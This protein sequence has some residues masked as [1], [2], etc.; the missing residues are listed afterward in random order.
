MVKFAGRCRRACRRNA[1][2]APACAAN[3]DARHVRRPRCRHHDLYFRHLP[4]A[5]RPSR[6]VQRPGPRRLRQSDELV[7]ETL[8]PEQPGPT[9]HCAGRFGAPRSP[10]R[11][12]SSRRRAWRSAP[13]GPRACR[14][15]T[16]PTW[17]FVT[18]P[19]P[20]ESRSR[21][22]RRCNRSSTCSAG[23]RDARRRGRAPVGSRRPGR[24]TACRKPWR[25]MQA[26]WKRGDQSVFVSMLGQLRPL[27][28]TPID[29]V[30]RAECPLGGLDRGADADA[31]H[32]VRRG[33]RRPS[34]RARTACS[35]ASPSAA[36]RRPGV[37]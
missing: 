34:R 27:R 11:R 23:C 4:R 36:S 9:K 16:A 25:D 17:C 22:S 32:R 10:R 13:A 37:N 12:L 21:A 29:D 14:S 30:H 19:R 1:D 5:R 7:L 6:M 31:G 2:D 3:A 8:V 24:W 26:A 15:A 35:S 20:T 33:R 18:L 28:R